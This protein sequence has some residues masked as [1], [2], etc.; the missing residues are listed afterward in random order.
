MS[1]MPDGRWPPVYDADQLAETIAELVYEGRLAKRFFECSAGPSGVCQGDIVALSSEVPILDRDGEPAAAETPIEFWL[2]TGNTCDFDRPTSDVRF[3]QMAPLIQ[4]APESEQWAALRGYQTS[5]RF[6]VPPWPGLDGD[7]H[8]VAD[9]T[10]QAAV[11]KEAFREAITVVARMGFEA[12]ILL[13]SCLVRFLCRDD[14][15]FD[16]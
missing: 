14:G 16:D 12:W 15:R 1:T 7:C 4:I 2:V 11:D 6:Y 9:F 13:H 8:Y 3:T 10:Q 5:R